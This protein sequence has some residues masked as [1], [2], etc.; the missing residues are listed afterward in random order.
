MLAGTGTATTTS[1]GRASP[2]GWTHQGGGEWKSSGLPS[3]V[4]P[5]PES[6]GLMAAAGRGGKKISL[7]AAGDEAS[8]HGLACGPAGDDKPGAGVVPSQEVQPGGAP[9]LGSEDEPSGTALTAAGGAGPGPSG[10]AALVQG[11]SCG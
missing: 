7:E 8:C 4:Q 1:A 2:W 9:R 5:P 10:D 11:A 3:Y 6:V